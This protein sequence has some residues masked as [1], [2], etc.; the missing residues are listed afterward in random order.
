MPKVTLL[1]TSCKGME[2]CGICAFVCPKSLFEVSGTMNEAGYLPP[3]QP[4]EAECTGCGNCMVF[5]PD[6]AIMVEGEALEEGEE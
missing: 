3:G 1:P 5:C 4:N 2:D 6:F